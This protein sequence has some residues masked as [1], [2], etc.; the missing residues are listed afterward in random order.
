MDE[1]KFV[2]KDQTLSVMTKV[3]FITI[4]TLKTVLF[5]RVDVNFTERLKMMRNGTALFGRRQF[6]F[7]K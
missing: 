4:V 5:G 1:A 7:V 3:L 6:F 2:I